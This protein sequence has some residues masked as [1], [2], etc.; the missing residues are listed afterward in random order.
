MYSTRASVRLRK[1]ARVLSTARRTIVTTPYS[2]PAP[3][4]SRLTDADV[5]AARKYCSN[6]LQYVFIIQ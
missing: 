1:S 3:H 2:T 5:D 4:A 6:L